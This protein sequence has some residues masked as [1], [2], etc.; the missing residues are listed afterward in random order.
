MKRFMAVGLA[1]LIVVAFAAPAGASD[2]S[3][4]KKL[5][6]TKADVGSGYTAK[7]GDSDPEGFEKLAECVG[8]P[9][10]KRKVTAR[11][12]GPDLL[13]DDGTQQVQSNVTVLKTKA[14]ARADRTVL[15]SPDLPDCYAE[16]IE[17]RGGTSVTSVDTQRAEVGEYGD[18][19]TA[20][21]AIIEFEE[22]GE[23]ATATGVEVAIIKGRAV[24]DATFLSDSDTPFNRQDAEAIL[25]KVAERLDKAE[26]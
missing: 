10:S 25:E 7:P 15:E 9:T 5:V 20:V 14:M 13:S 6:I 11:V 18:Y 16:L 8:G 3:T 22:N 1:G 17:E 2:K 26:V 19:S 12:D 23:P 24:L 4:A 21:L